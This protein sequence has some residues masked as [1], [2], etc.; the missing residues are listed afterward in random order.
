MTDRR[1]LVQVSGSVQEIPTGDTVPLANGGTAA[2]DA[3]GARTNLGL[4]IGTNVQAYDAT[5]AALAAYNTNG[6]LTQTAADTFTGRTLTGTTN[7]ITVTNGNGISGNPSIDIASAYA[8]QNTIVT[9]G[10]ITTGTWNAGDITATN[11]TSSGVFN[12]NYPTT[13][14]TV[15]AFIQSVNNGTDL[16]HTLN[17][18]GVGVWNIWEVS[19]GSQSGNIAYSTP[20]GHLGIIISRGTTASPTDRFNI[21]NAATN[22]GLGFHADDGGFRG[23]TL[24]IWPG[25][26]GTA[27]GQVAIGVTT[28]ASV[29]TAPPTG[30]RLHVGTTNAAVVPVRIRLAASQTANGL[31]M[32][33]SGGTNITKINSAGW[34][35]IG[36]G[37]TA[38]AAPV[39]VIRNTFNMARFE[40]TGSGG[41]GFTCVEG[42]GANAVNF[43]VAG[44]SANFFAGVDGGADNFLYADTSTLNVKSGQSIGWV[45]SATNAVGTPDTSFTR[46][47]AGAIGTTSTFTVTNT[48]NASVTP[49][50][51][52]NSS[53]GSSNQTRIQILNDAGTGGTDGAMFYLNGANNSDP[54]AFGI[55]SYES[56]RFVLGVNA[57]VQM[58][59]NSS[60]LC[61]VKGFQAGESVTTP[62]YLAGTAAGTMNV[63][64]ES[65]GAAVTC[66]TLSTSA[67]GAVTVARA[68]GTA[69]SPTALQNG[70]AIGDLQF[71]AYDGANTQQLSTYI[72]GVVDGAVSATVTPISMIFV[73]GS[74]L[75]TRATRMAISSAG[76]VSVT[77]NGA[78]SLVPFFVQG[79]ASQTGN[80][81]EWRNSG[82]TALASVNSAGFVTSPNVNRGVTNTT[83]SGNITLTATST[84]FQFINPNGVNRDVNLQSSP[85]TGASYKIKNT[86]SSGGF[87]L[88]VKNSGGTQI[89]SNVA[90]G[91]TIEVVFDGTNW[92]VV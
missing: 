89:G 52:I 50:R 59:V 28:S 35:G 61:R 25:G 40:R 3:A 7:R 69:A 51:V 38:V 57:A 85:A 86:A 54:H 46:V 80:L 13:S 91:A 66:T 83:A 75:A 82:G 58:D 8:G 17:S 47:S 79:V 49:I 55:Y 39:H 67:R 9:L 21:V 88:V 34:L 14:K 43:G 29:P 70:D 24:T 81:Q 90:N 74:N 45:S 6:L 22:F 78:T 63:W 5:L 31:E 27:Q 2:T 37:A 12:Q 64:R 68:R 73:T 77:N 4:A 62:A 71:L 1:P 16:I 41:A 20:G 53:T 32:E 10:T 44:G 76:Q 42:V 48:A 72:G 18:N 92:Q 15:P 87:V 30:S 23:N 65:G 84:Y 26:A 33:N 60:G 11:V 19:G 36:L 56:G